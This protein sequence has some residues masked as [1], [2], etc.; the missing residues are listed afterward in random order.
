MNFIENLNKII[1]LA[2]IIHLLES[3]FYHMWMQLIEKIKENDSEK[4]LLEDY[5]SHK[6]R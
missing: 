4:P 5:G 3:I 1:F 6:M 2:S